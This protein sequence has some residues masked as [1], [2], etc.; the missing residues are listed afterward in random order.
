MNHK[1]LD[2]EEVAMVYNTPLNNCIPDPCVKG[3]VNLVETDCVIF[4][5]PNLRCRDV[6]AVNKGET[7]T[8]VISNIVTFMCKLRNDLDSLVIK[9]NNLES[10]V[11]THTIQIE[12]LYELISECCNGGAVCNPPVLG[13]YVLP[14]M[15]AGQPYTTVIAYTGTVATTVVVSTLPSGLTYTSGN[16]II[17]ITGTPV[18]SGAFTVNIT[19]TNACGTSSKSYATATCIVPTISQADI[20]TFKNKVRTVGDVVNETISISGSTPIS[21][22]VR[23]AYGLNATISGNVITI[24]GTIN[25]LNFP[26]SRFEIDYSNVCGNG[27]VDLTPTTINNQ[28]TPLQINQ[29]VL[30]SATVDSAYNATAVNVTAGTKPFTVT[31]WSAPAGL[32]YVINQDSVSITGT[33]TDSSIDQISFTISNGC[34]SF[35]LLFIMTYCVKP[36]IERIDGTNIDALIDIFLVRQ[37]GRIVDGSS[38]MTVSLVGTLQANLSIAI[39]RNSNLL[40]LTTPAVFGDVIVLIGA[41]SIPGTVNITYEVT[42]QCG[43]SREYSS[44]LFV[45][46]EPPVQVTCPVITSLGKPNDAE[47]AT[48]L[49][50]DTLNLTWT[51]S[52]GATSKYRLRVRSTIPGNSDIIDTIQTSTT[53]N[54][55]ISTPMFTV[56]H[57]YQVTVYPLASNGEQLAD[58]PYVTLFTV[59][60]RCGIVPYNG[61]VK[62]EPNVWSMAVDFPLM[63][64]KVWMALTIVN[65]DNILIAGPIITDYGQ[66][67]NTFT[68]N[69]VQYPN[70]TFNSTENCIEV[71]HSFILELCN[72]E[73]YKWRTYRK[74]ERRP[75]GSYFDRHAMYGAVPEISSSNSGIFL[76]YIHR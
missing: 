46:P 26:T 56:G 64:A 62:T 35:D 48:V 12:E 59:A 1:C 6:F 24:T 76:P 22:V 15:V 17:Q 44:V 11:S 30:P 10:T 27:T 60:D 75:D 2:C 13:N 3:C 69:T 36:I 23:Q 53:Y 55:P 25:N 29:L 52:G 67:S 19:V 45:A 65:C 4:S 38:P 42:N 9:V 70:Y 37:L 41:T 39:S 74:M 72:G 5:G 28:C 40:P 54:S 32:N 58:C 14:F 50:G 18:N 61:F 20:N 66:L 71:T 34:S 49:L 51:Q 33:T 43:Q 57:A 21:I 7:S 47:Y 31:N 16:N 73:T 68:Y 8:Q 63:S